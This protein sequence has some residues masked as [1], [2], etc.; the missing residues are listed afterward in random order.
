MYMIAVNFLHPCRRVASPWHSDFTAIVKRVRNEVV[1]TLIR[2]VRPGSDV[3]ASDL[4]VG[5][6]PCV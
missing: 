5:N 1:A 2:S 6:D 4:R 3:L